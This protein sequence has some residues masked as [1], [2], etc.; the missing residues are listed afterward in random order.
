MKHYF[1][2]NSVEI[3]WSRLKP[4][5]VEADIN[6]VME[7]CSKRLKSIGECGAKDLTYEKTLLAFE[8]AT[9]ELNNAWTKVG[10]LEAVSNS[11]ELREVYN[12]MLPKVS[13]FS[14]NI[15][16]DEKLWRV[17]KAYWKTTEAR[18]LKGI[19][20]RFLEETLKDFQ[21]S[22]AD[23]SKED[24]K[25][26]AKIEAKL[27]QVTQKYSENVLDATNAWDL[28][29]KNEKE[30]KGLPVSAKKAARENALAKGYGS[31]KQP[32]WRFTLQSPSVQPVMQYLESDSIRKKVWE[33]N[34]QVGWQAPY[35][36]TAL[37]KQILKLRQEKAELLGKQHF[38][39]WVL[40]R[41]MA[42]TGT[43]ALKFIEDLYK[44]IRKRFE[45]EINLLE[46]YKANKLNQKKEPLNPWEMAYWAEKRKKELF[47]FDD[48]QMRPYFPITQV[49]Q[50]MF[51]LV[52][53]LY[54]IK[55]V[56]P[57]RKVD[58]WHPE[59]KFYE[60]FDGKR[61][62]IGS[63]YADW[64]PRESKRGGAWM[65]HLYTGKKGEPHVG[66][67]CGNLTPPLRGKDALLT[68]L[69]VETIFHEFGHLLHHL[70]SEVEVKA[71]HGTH[72]AWDFVELPSQIMEN[73]CWE[74][75]SLDLFARH[76]KT[77]ERIP[78]ALFKKLIGVRNYLSGL[79]MMRQ[80]SI[81]KMDL[82][83]HICYK[84]YKNRNLDA[85][86]DEI[87][88]GY[89]PKFKTKGLNLVRRL[90]HVFADPTGY[91]AGYYSYKWAEVLDAD[92]FTRFK[93]EGILSAKVGKEFR[94]KILAQGNSAPAE[95][96]YKN[97]MGRQPRVEAL[98][99]RA[100]IF[101]KII[102]STSDE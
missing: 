63:F 12:K 21:E 24:K 100:G 3:H 79:E 38:A 56:E 39:D 97:F 20:K 69:E 47:D 92:A 60:V 30:L 35:D 44:K 37:I 101:E 99:E 16:L 77:G 19:R 32:Q 93:K 52:E 11:P 40:Q 50:G 2:D 48:E 54:G 78:V 90:T 88:K 42:K 68:H 14:T 31:K 18:R 72:V 55:I 46:I 26:L 83:L 36:N 22:G 75:E 49:I 64:H 67:I 65:N 4:K 76:Y 51:S 34:A 15:H 95:E 102:D 57:K 53:K 29:I 45:E 91:A 66:V 82:A 85:V 58:T 62:H 74:R 6:K 7:D 5:F 73:W 87:V 23:L 84:K 61:R 96:L 89:V 43:K 80:L 25:K 8:E 81:A 13:R 59:V 70:L 71:L 41:R 94:E 9:E 33:A 28:V 10:H 86:V 27:A 98:L 1:L 17:L